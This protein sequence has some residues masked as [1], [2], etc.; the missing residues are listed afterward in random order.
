M[1]SFEVMRWYG[2]REDVSL[3]ECINVFSTGVYSAEDYGDDTMYS[4]QDFAM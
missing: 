2:L 1:G 3:C 4:V